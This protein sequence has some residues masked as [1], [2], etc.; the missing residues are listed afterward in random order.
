MESAAS[1]LDTFGSP[2]LGA[3]LGNSL[4]VVGSVIEVHPT[5][6]S[7]SS[8]DIVSIDPSN[9]SASSSQNAHEV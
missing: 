5:M 6:V 8:L 3:S 2:S 7:P 1:Q 9:H 4:G